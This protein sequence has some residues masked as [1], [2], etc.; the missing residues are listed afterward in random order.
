MSFH[1]KSKDFTLS[2]ENN[3]SSKRGHVTN[4]S[5]F[6]EARFETLKESLK[7]IYKRLLDD[8]IL[9][10]MREDHSSSD[11]I[12]ERIEEIFNEVIDNDREEL[13][14]KFAEKYQVLKNQ[15]ED[16]LIEK[17]KVKKKT[18]YTSIN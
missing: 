18:P 12:N 5:K 15:Y 9:K 11:F 1:P 16:L 10:V 6:H 4:Q 17:E 3:F 7:G 13:L 2:Y 14:N 8:E